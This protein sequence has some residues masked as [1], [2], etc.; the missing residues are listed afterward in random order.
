MSPRTSVQTKMRQM[1]G[2]SKDMTTA[3]AFQVKQLIY[4]L[5]DS[6]SFMLDKIWKIVVCPWCDISN[7]KNVTIALSYS[8]RHKRKELSYCDWPLLDIEALNK[9][10]TSMMER[11]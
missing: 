1:N 7:A 11:Y 8:F 5:L 3:P 9:Q 2:K 4:C 10:C 6:G